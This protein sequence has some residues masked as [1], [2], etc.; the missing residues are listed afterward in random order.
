MLLFS[1]AQITGAS[2]GQIEL[3]VH[4]PLKGSILFYKVYYTLKLLNYKLN[5]V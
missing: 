5:S 3:K 2:Y 1:Q 4:V